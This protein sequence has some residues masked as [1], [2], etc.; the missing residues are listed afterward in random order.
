MPSATNTAIEDIRK[1]RLLAELLDNRIREGKEIVVFNRGDTFQIPN[2]SAPGAAAKVVN[3]NTWCC[4]FMTYKDKDGSTRLERLRKYAGDD[5]EINELLDK[6]LS[7]MPSVTNTVIEDI[8]KVRLLAELLDNRIREGNEIVI[9]GQRD[10]YLIPNWSKPGAA[11]KVINPYSWC[12][13]FM[14]YKDKDG[15][16]RLERLREYAGDDPEI[17]ELLD[18]VLSKMPAVTDPVIIE[19]IRKVRILAELLDNRIREGNEIVIFGKRDN[20]LIPNWSKPGAAAK[21]VNPYN[22]CCKFMTKKRNDGSTRLERLREYAG[23]DPEINELLD[24]VLSKMILY[25]RRQR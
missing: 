10:K 12:C 13:K 4:T 18:K 17:N 22:W 9:F 23:D 3:P 15:S 21:V 11:A 19:D 8:R 2:W 25:R 7:K 6:V 14:T 5:P 1:F 20:Y 24:K 16:T